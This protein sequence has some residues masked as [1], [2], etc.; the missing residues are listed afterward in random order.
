M[1]S[2]DGSSRPPA[3]LR[4]AVACDQSLVAESVA[5]ALDHQGLEVVRVPWPRLGPVV[6]RSSRRVRSARGPLGPPPDVGLVVSDLTRVA[7]VRGA[8]ALVAGLAVP[9][10]VMTGAPRGAAWGGVYERGV[11]LVV[12]D[13]TGLDEVRGLLV[14]LA[15]GWQPADQRRARR[16]LVQAWLAFAEQRDDL[17]ARLQTLTQREEEVLQRLHEGLPVRAIA[18]GWEVAEATVRSQVKA[19]LKKLGVGSQM[20]AVSAYEGLLTDSTDLRR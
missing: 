6:D 14:D 1:A 12:A 16:E 10:L 17:A 11:R 20:A 19:I 2:R 9:W 4:V 3:G 13:D 15:T 18:E 8:A 7:Q 5:T